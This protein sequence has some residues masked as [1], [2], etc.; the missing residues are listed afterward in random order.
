MG[1]GDRF[2]QTPSQWLSG[3]KICVMFWSESVLY[4]RGPQNM[5]QMLLRSRNE[6]IPGRCK[7]NA[8]SDQADP[9]FPSSDWIPSSP[10]FPNFLP[11]APP[12]TASPRHFVLQH[13]LE[14][15]CQH[16]LPSLCAPL[17]IT[18][19]SPA[20]LTTYH[21]QLGALSTVGYH[22]EHHYRSRRRGVF[23]ICNFYK[24]LSWEL[25]STGKVLTKVLRGQL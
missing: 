13:K 17:L 4:E 16:W 10:L 14:V 23:I 6:C 15:L 2:Q 12:H 7:G 18:L 9:N 22:R 21:F 19:C 11:P 20:Q 8:W 1:E 5:A 24:E 3:I 25:Q